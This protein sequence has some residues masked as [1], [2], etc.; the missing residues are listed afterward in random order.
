MALVYKEESFEER[1]RFVHVE[2]EHIVKR[3]RLIPTEVTAV[4]GKSAVRSL[5]ERFLETVLN[6]T[7]DLQ[8]SFRELFSFRQLR[9]WGCVEA[10]S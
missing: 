6:H 7:R 2:D 1:L 10:M 9:E 3:I 5:Y 8:E 4:M